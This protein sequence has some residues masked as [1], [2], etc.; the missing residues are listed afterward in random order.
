[1]QSGSLL[2]TCGKKA[3]NERF[4]WPRA[5]KRP[6]LKAWLKRLVPKRGKQKGQKKGTRS[7]QDHREKKKKTWLKTKAEGEQLGQKTNGDPSRKRRIHGRPF[8]TKE[9]VPSHRE[10]GNI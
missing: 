4:K 9:K 7:S 10:G 3:L 1:V 6:P 8:E 5:R 2:W